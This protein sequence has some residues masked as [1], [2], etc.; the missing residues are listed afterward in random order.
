MIYSSSLLHWKNIETS[1]SII[2]SD[3]FIGAKNQALLKFYF[4]KLG[5]TQHYRYIWFSFIWEFSMFALLHIHCT[6]HMHTNYAL[7]LDEISKFCSETTCYLIV[8]L[9]DRN[10]RYMALNNFVHVDWSETQDS[11]RG[12]HRLSSLVW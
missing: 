10:V 8:P 11:F 6:Y 4:D 3:I 2:F 12:Y 5:G 7:S 1:R 9:H